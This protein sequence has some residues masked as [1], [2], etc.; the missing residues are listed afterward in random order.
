MIICQRNL[1]DLN[2]KINFIV[3]NYSKIQNEMKKNNL[4]TRK[5]FL[6]ELKSILEDTK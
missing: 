4:P 2:K 1:E 3:E 5:N 6:E